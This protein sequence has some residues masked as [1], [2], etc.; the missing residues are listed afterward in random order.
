[1]HCGLRAVLFVQRE[2]LLEPYRR[3]KNLQGGSS[4]PQ[5]IDTEPPQKSDVKRQKRSIRLWI[6]D[7]E[8]NVRDCIRIIRLEGVEKFP[9]LVSVK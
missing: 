6:D 8:R 2:R 7:D 9:P 3:S 1:M 5:A 4:I